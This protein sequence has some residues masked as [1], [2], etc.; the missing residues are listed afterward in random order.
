MTFLL[1]FIWMPPY[2]PGS[3]RCD[4]MRA[5]PCIYTI[6]IH[7]VDNRSLILKPTD[8]HQYR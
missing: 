2:A 1:N 3:G 6:E 7:H 5:D 8:I 4:S